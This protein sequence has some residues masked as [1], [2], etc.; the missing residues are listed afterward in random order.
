MGWREKRPGARRLRIAV[1]I[2]LGLFCC[3][4]EAQTISWNTTSGSWTDSANWSPQNVPDQA[5]E[6]ALFASPVADSAD[7]TLNAP[8]T[9]GTLEMSADHPHLTIQSVGNLTVNTAD[10]SST[11]AQI[12]VQSGGAVNATSFVTNSTITINAGGQ[13]SATHYVQARGNGG[14]ISGTLDA[15]SGSIEVNQGIITADGAGMIRCNA[16]SVADQSGVTLQNGG[17]LQTTSFDLNGE[18]RLSNGAATS[19]NTIQ[20]NGSGIVS[21]AGTLSSAQITDQ[22]VVNPGF[23][24][25]ATVNTGA[26]HFTGDLVFQNTP[27][28]DPTNLQIDITS[29]GHDTVYVDGAATLSTYLTVKVAGSYIPATGSEYVILT[30]DSIDTTGIDYEHAFAEPELA[31][32]VSVSNDDGVIGSFQLI[33]RLMGGKNEL[34]LAHF[35][36]VPEP[37]AA[38]IVLGLVPLVRRPR[39]CS[40]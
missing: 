13:L 10:I 31:D 39:R 26:L 37:S 21:G 18:L 40:M 3:A 5:S 32:Y 12:L 17:Q 36:A 35:S 14:L 25:G 9:I 29:T 11:A 7:V 22:S 1:A 28:Q 24:S 20:V 6:A 8:I 19:T 23:R 34:V 30:A 16:I 15:S 33:K 38:L 2:G 27:D 4:S